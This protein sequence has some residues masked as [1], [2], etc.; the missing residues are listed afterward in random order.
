MKI[1]WMVLVAAMLS[2]SGCLSA[3]VALPGGVTVSGLHEAGAQEQGARGNTHGHG[4]D[5]GR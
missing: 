5:D 1:R 3:S 4:A 2:L